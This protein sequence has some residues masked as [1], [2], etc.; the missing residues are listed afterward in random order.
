MLRTATAA[1]MVA[2]M[3]IA[4]IGKASALE[5]AEGTAE[6]PALDTI[7]QRIVGWAE[8]RVDRFERRMEALD[9]RDG[10]RATQ[11]GAL[12][13]DGVAIFTGMIDEVTAAED[14]AG[15]W[16]A[17]RNA[18]TEYRE[19]RRVRLGHAHV[20]ADVDRFTRRVIRL[21]TLIAR[22]Q[23][24]DLDTGSA[25]EEAEAARADLEP[26]EALL[27]GIDPSAIGPDV[28]EQLGQ[29]H[30][31]AHDAQAHLRAGLVALR[32]AVGAAA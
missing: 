1:T 11:L 12:F 3:A 29:A 23:D 7:K 20:E 26:A 24:A 32:A 19:H 4:G 13:G 25:A 5:A 21:E 27:T 6:A 30:R 28:V 2:L 22:A 15:V 18:G 9:G 16:T 17:V 14:L 8:G 10:P 31:A